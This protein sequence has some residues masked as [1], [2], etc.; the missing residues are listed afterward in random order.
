MYSQKNV[1]INQL[2]NNDSKIFG[3][4]IMLIFDKTKSAKEDFYGPKKKQK[5]GMLMF[6]IQSSQN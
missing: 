5:F 4:I 3:S 6:I 2:E 1:C